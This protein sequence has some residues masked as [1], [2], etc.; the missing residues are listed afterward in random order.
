MADHCMYQVSTLQALSLG[1]SRSV[2]R[3]PDSPAF[4][5]YSLREA[6]QEEIRKVEQSPE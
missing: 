2:I 4:D 5:T 3:L 6:S 1:C